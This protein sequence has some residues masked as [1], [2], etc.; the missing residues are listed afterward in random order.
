MDLSSE[1]E[2]WAV[3]T[4]QARRF[5]KRENY[6]DAVARMS[7]VKRSIEEALRNVGDTADR[8]ELEAL[9]LRA[10]EQL[11]TLRESYEAWRS[12]IA[13]RRQQTIDNA[14]EEMARPIPTHS[15]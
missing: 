10:T 5:A 1:K 14:A 7:L 11:E 15:E 3:W 9:L 4:V 13:A 12:A 6:T 2:R 8:K